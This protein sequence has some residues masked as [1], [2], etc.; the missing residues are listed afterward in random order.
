MSRNP[1][2]AVWVKEL[3]ISRYRMTDAIVPQI[4]PRLTELQQLSL[5]WGGNLK[6]PE[7]KVLTFP[8]LLILSLAGRAEIATVITFLQP[9][10][11]WTFG[12]SVCIQVQPGIRQSICPTLLTSACFSAK[13]LDQL[14]RFPACQNVFITLVRVTG[15]HEM[16]DQ[17]T[18]YLPN[19]K[20]CMLAL[21]HNTDPIPSILSEE[22]SGFKTLESFVVVV[23]NRLAQWDTATKIQTCLVSCPNLTECAFLNSLMDNDRYKIIDGKAQPTNDLSRMEFFSKVDIKLLLDESDGLGPAGLTNTVTWT[24]KIRS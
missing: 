2:Y 8:R 7:F 1:Q 18:H 19:L 24:P 5:G 15:M 10:Y 13:E 16:F 6:I 22:L 4:L 17:L 21:N 9:F 12:T 3:S 14:A 23:S 11:I 20:C